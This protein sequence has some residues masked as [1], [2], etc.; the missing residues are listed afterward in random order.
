MHMYICACDIYI[1]ICNFGTR[2]RP[3]CRGLA[4]TAITLPQIAQGA[5]PRVVLRSFFMA[6]LVVMDGGIACSSAKVNS[7][8]HNHTELR[9]MQRKHSQRCYREMKD[10]L[11]SMLVPLPKDAIHAVD[12][13]KFR[14]TLF[15]PIDISCQWCG[16]WH[17]LPRNLN[18]SLP[19]KEEHADSPRLARARHIH[20]PVIPLPIIHYPEIVPAPSSSISN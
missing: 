1:Y 5:S 16:S 3:R 6:N 4:K 20:F 13:E 10:K 8:R 12:L 19:I 15:L 17:P 2:L 18:V 7:V 9:R 11:V 14:E